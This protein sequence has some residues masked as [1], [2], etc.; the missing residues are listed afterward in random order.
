MESQLIQ[1]SFQIIQ[2]V[3]SEV[4][5][6]ILLIGRHD[7]N[8]FRIKS[9]CFR[10]LFGSFL[11]HYKMNPSRRVNK[12]DFF[13]TAISVLFSELILFWVL[14]VFPDF[15]FQTYKFL[16]PAMNSGAAQASKS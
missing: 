1:K 11:N 4:T 3:I 15:H 8:Q 5:S 10:Q 16:Q 13:T 14:F 12:S 7:S 9:D 6:V 2:N